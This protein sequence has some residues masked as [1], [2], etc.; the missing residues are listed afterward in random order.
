MPIEIVERVHFLARRGRCPNGIDFLDRALV[1]TDGDA[2]DDSVESEEDDDEN[3]Y[4]EG[5]D[6]PY[7]EDDGELAEVIEDAHIGEDDQAYVGVDDD[8][9]PQ[10][11]GM[12]EG[13]APP[14]E[15][16]EENREDE[17]DNIND[18]DRRMTYAEAAAARYGP[19]NS[20]YNLRPQ[21][22]RDYSHLH[23]TLEHTVMTQH[24]MK[25]GLKLFGDAGTDAVLKELR[26]LHEREALEPTH[27]ESMTGEERRE[28]LAYLMFLKQ[29]RNGTVKGRGCADGR[30]QRVYT[31][32]E[33]TSSPTVATES[34]F[35]SCVVD[36]KENRDVC[37][38]DI[39]N[40]FLQ[41]KMEG[42]VYMKLEGTMADLLLQI[43]PQLY[44]KFARKGAR[45]K[46]VLYVRLRKALYGTLK[47]ALLFWRHLSLSLKK[48][49]FEANPYDQCVV[50]KTINGKQC[51]ILW[52]VDDLKISHV[53]PK[54]VTT[55]I[56]DLQSEFGQEAPLTITR[57]RVHEYL[58]MTIDYRTPG[59]VKVTMTDYIQGMLKELPSDMDGESITPAGNHL[60]QVN[61]KDPEYLDT[62]KSE[63]Y[64]HNAAKLLFLCK[65]A[66]PDIQTAVAFL[67]TRVKRPDQDDYK[68]LGRV[69]RYLR[70]TLDMPLTL[71]AEST[72]V[73]KWWVDASFAVHPDMRSHTGGI[74]SL[75][76]GAIYSSS[77]K[78][79]LNTRSSTESELVG[80]SD[81]MPQVLWT[82][83]FLSAQGYDTSDSVVYQDNQSCMLMAKNGR[84]SSSKRTRHIDIRYFFV[85]DRIAA[86]DLSVAYCPTGEMVADFF[87]K[88]LQ[89]TPFRKFRDFIMNNESNSTAAPATN[90]RNVLE[91]KVHRADD[92]GN[93]STAKDKNVD[94]DEVANGP[95]I[96]VTSW[97]RNGRTTAIHDVD[98]ETRHHTDMVKQLR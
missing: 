33:E 37:T 4:D 74:M 6:D 45:G 87:T 68:K 31:S 75:G 47:A 57:G 19:R 11:A 48:Q 64:H 5:D 30:R 29:K 40:A 56:A 98:T 59:K 70:G 62:D 84:A 20:G 79:K 88:P 97:R 67:C 9:E 50:N 32:K 2:D 63:F 83:R 92:D 12:P 28:A 13:D 46:T 69:M 27:P 54:V 41:A 82:R 36:A 16:P 39:P 66:R 23:T 78:Q 96:P 55:V 72:S 17:L 53:D 7:P 3:S 44:V 81:L 73:I 93:I 94:V 38:V 26:Q 60:F 1:P 85:A 14:G 8:H 52:H 76:R 15:T 95:W 89:G 49:G 34:V 25:A 35:L 77:T 71:E 21:R 18:Q 22:P 24:S 58:G 51:T 80:I 86:G 10:L 65:R 61:K 91:M 43:D 90:S 42:V